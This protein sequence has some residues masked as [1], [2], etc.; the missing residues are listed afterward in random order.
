MSDKR[1]EIRDAQVQIEDIIEELQDK[2]NI[3]IFQLKVVSKR[4][5]RPIIHLIEDKRGAL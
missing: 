4:G 2:E 3:C 1:E 5:D